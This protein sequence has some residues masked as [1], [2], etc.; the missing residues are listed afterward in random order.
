M[1][2]TEIKDIKAEL[3][4]HFTIAVGTRKCAICGTKHIH[5]G[6]KHIVFSKSGY[7]FSV[8]HVYIGIECVK[9]LI[10]GEY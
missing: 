9:G 5:R 1:T 2:N 8:V 6:D 3:P 4:E 10:K 7:K